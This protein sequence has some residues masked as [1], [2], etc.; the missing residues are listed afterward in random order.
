MT[1]YKNNSSTSKAASDA[2]ADIS[3]EKPD[4]A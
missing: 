1:P 3:A 2:R 4:G